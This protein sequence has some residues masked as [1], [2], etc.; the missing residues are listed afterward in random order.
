[1]NSANV[2]FTPLEFTAKLKA[3]RVAFEGI[4]WYD[5]E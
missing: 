3:Q 5:I 2:D 4:Y 1:M